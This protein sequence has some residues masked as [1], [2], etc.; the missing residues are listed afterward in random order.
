MTVGLSDD[1][2][3]SKSL[4]VRRNSVAAFALA[5]SIAVPFTPAIALVP[6]GPIWA[7][8]AEADQLITKIQLETWKAQKQRRQ[9]RGGQCREYDNSNDCRRTAGCKWQTGRPLFGGYCYP[10]APPKTGL[11]HKP[12]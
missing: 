12:R 1:L 7:G 4:R 6:G 5:V 3:K 11:G 8:S 10:T 9:A 2:S